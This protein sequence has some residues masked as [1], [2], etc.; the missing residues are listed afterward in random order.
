MRQK[1]EDEK[2]DELKQ[3]DRERET[4]TIATSLAATTEDGYL[5]HSLGEDADAVVA[6][7]LDDL[8]VAVR[9]D[10]VVGEPD[11]SRNK[12]EQSCGNRLRQTLSPQ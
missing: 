9:V 5:N 6:V 2:S 10:G 1:V 4:A 12:L 3:E 7:D 8:G 11:Q